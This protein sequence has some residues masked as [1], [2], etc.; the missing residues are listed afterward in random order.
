MSC[1][2]TEYELPETEKKKITQLATENT[3]IIRYELA[4]TDTDN[5]ILIDNK[6]IKVKAISDVNLTF[7]NTTLRVAGVSYNSD[8][9]LQ[10]QDYFLLD[11][12]YIQSGDIIAL[13]PTL[14]PQFQQA[15]IKTTINN[16]DFS[17]HAFLD[18][19]ASPLLVFNVQDPIGTTA[20]ITLSGYNRSNQESYTI[21]PIQ[22]NISV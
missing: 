15:F 8:T 20:T 1:N 2:G 4:V 17:G 6:D 7:K 21:T 5:D 12:K 13:T 14:V 11:T 19:N 22:K 3:R 9:F 10:A 18:Y 16:K